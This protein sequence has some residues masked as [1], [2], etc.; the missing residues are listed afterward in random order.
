M[1]YFSQYSLTLAFR[2]PYLLFFFININKNTFNA[3]ATISGNELQMLKYMKKLI[4]VI[5]T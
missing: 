2:R 5:Y 1:L 4:C 3:V